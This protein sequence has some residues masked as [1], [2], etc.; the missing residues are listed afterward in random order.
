MSGGMSTKVVAPGEHHA[1]A[2]DDAELPEAAEL[3]RDQRRVGDAGRER[4]RQRPL[5]RP[6]Q[7]EGQRL[8]DR[9]PARRSST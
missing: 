4:R 5:A 7:R 1:E 8:L 6:P 3:H 9:V 2:A